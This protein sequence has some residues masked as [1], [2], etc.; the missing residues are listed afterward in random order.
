MARQCD[1]SLIETNLLKCS[2]HHPSG[3]E[4][5]HPA[6]YDTSLLLEREKQNLLRMQTARDLMEQINIHTRPQERCTFHPTA[7]INKDILGRTLRLETR[8]R[9]RDLQKLDEQIIYY[10][11]TKTQK[12]N[13]QKDCH[14]GVG[15]HSIYSRLIPE[16]RK[17]M[18]LNKTSS[19]SFSVHGTTI[20]PRSSIL[21]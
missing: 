7:A 12:Y 19:I 21:E 1:D 20:N 8:E 15:D 4:A 2:I 14:R 11:N 17:S 10:A 18:S 5:L 13:Y 9:Q 6:I 3:P 16:L